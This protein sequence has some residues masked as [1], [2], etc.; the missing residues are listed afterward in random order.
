MK[1]NYNVWLLWLF[2]LFILSKRTAPRRRGSLGTLCH[3]EAPL[4]GR[5]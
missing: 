1:T 5:F 2:I 4:A 3:A